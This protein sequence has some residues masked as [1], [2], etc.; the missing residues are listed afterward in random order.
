M[1][2]KIKDIEL[3]SNINTIY[4]LYKH[5]SKLKVIKILSLNPSCSIQI[6]RFKYIYLNKADKKKKPEGVYSSM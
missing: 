5:K 1:T 4:I 3:G 2:Y 6:K